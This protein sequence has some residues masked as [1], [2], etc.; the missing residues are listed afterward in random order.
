MAVLLLLPWRE[1]GARPWQVSLVSQEGLRWIPAC[2]EPA[3]RIERGNDEGTAFR[4]KK[5]Q[6]DA[7]PNSR[8][9]TGLI[10]VLALWLTARSH[11]SPRAERPGLI[12]YRQRRGTEMNPVPVSTPFDKLRDRKEGVGTGTPRTPLIRGQPQN[13]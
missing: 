9:L 13:Q 12:A 1:V 5:S 7:L 3:L 11:V 2:A 10:E 6:T 8:V 4:P